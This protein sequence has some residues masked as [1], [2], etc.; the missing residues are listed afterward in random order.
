VGAENSI[1]S[2]AAD[3]GVPLFLELRGGAPSDLLFTDIDPNAPDRSRGLSRFFTDLGHI[4]PVRSRPQ[5]TAR[6]DR[7]L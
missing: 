6:V 5:R 3:R 1:K 4:R 2:A 7:A